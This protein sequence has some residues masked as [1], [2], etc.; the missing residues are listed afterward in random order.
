MLSIYRLPHTLPNE[1]V[2][3]VIR[4]D[5]FV[6][7]K[8]VLLFLALAMLPLIFFAMAATT[9]PGL[10]AN[11]LAYALIV[12]GA[13]AYY[14]FI[15]MFFFF[16]FLDYYLDVWIITTERIIDIRQEG[17]F[18]RTIAE[19][20]LHQIQDV[21]SEVHGMVAT[22]LRFG[23]VHV[24]TAG[25]QQRFHFDEIPDPD[26]VRDTIIKLVE[27]KRHELLREEKVGVA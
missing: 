6:I 9:Q 4:R 25:A 12:L 22:I 21:T 27:N 8:R 13:S 18:S 15:W 5:V 7:F 17:F 20:K 14:L 1:K 26:G 2:I 19:N 24:Q 3:K 11:E 23:D 16:S 10:F